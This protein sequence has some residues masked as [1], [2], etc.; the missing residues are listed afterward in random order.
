MKKKSKS[1]NPYTVSLEIVI[2]LLFKKSYSDWQKH[3]SSFAAIISA[4]FCASS[5]MIQKSL[6]LS[7]GVPT[8]HPA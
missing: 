2:E 5:G 1:K 7:T 3:L 8:I 4:P 6:D